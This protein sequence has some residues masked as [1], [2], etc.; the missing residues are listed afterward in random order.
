MYR[1][2]HSKTA[3]VVQIQGIGHTRVTRHNDVYKTILIYATRL[4]PRCGV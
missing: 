2:T 3:M 1:N 4:T